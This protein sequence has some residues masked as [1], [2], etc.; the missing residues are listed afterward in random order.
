MLK[1]IEVEKNGKIREKKKPSLAV[2]HLIAISHT[3]LTED[4]EGYIDCQSL[5]LNHELVHQSTARD[6]NEAANIRHGLKYWYSASK[7]LF[8]V[9]SF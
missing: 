3:D 2:P 4:T 9:A 8:F 6:E 7:F 5:S 1:N